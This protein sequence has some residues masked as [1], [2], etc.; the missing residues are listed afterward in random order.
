MESNVKS[1]DLGDRHVS[2]HCIAAIF[3]WVEI[4]QNKIGEGKLGISKTL[5]LIC[6]EMKGKE[7]LGKNK[8]IL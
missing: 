3:L 4:F 2:G 5:P 8:N 7:M 6:S 1:E